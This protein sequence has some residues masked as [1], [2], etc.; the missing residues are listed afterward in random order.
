MNDRV[1]TTRRYMSPRRIS[2]YVVAVVALGMGAV[3]GALGYLVASNPEPRGAQ[4][5]AVGEVFTVG[6]R[7]PFVGDLVVYG[8]PPQGER[9]DLDA[10][11]CQATEGEASLSTTVAATQDR[12][13][14]DGRGVV[15]LVSFPGVEGHSIACNGPAAVTAAPL[16]VVPGSS[17]R[18]LLPL[19]GYSVAALLLPVGFVIVL[20]LGSTRS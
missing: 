19:A 18:D 1:V 11:G 4:P 9:P 15:P 12:I 5:I 3:A 6:E 2:G 16:Y 8:T 13:V 14:V 10:L 20:M 17:A 7:V